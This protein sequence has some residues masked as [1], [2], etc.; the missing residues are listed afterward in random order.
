M[1]W[2]GRHGRQPLYSASASDAHSSAGILRPH[3]ATTDNSAARQPTVAWLFSTET[4]K[5]RGCI[6]LPGI[7]FLTGSSGVTAQ[8]PFGFALITLSDISSPWQ[9]YKMHPKND[10]RDPIDVRFTFYLLTYLSPWISGNSIWHDFDCQVQLLYS[11]VTLILPISI[12]V[13]GVV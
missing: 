12:V 7:P 11:T 10:D 9:N 6:R 13:S 5:T 4:I 3:S 2:Y 8:R 1:K